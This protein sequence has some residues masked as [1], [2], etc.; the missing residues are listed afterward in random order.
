MVTLSPVSPRHAHR[1]IDREIIRSFQPIHNRRVML[2]LALAALVL[3]AVIA[4][5]VTGFRGRH[6]TRGAKSLTNEPAPTL[7]P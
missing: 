4:S 1:D 6:I 3:I 5:V 2:V 7:V